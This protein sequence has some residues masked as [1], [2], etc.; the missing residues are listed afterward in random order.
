MPSRRP[1]FLLVDT[2]VAVGL[3]VILTLAMVATFRQFSN[4][5]EYV[6]VRQQARIDA[7]TELNR[8]RA[9]GL[10]GAPSTAPALPD[11]ATASLETRMEPGAGEWAGMTRVTVVAGRRVRDRWITVELSTY[12]PAAEGVR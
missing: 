12:L 7:E 10:D 11:V 3:T 5:R 8:L 1:G 4:S 6:N 2:I 9:G